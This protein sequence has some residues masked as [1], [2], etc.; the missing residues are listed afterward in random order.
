MT[1]PARDPDAGDNTGV[2]PD[3]EATTGRPRWQKVIGIVGLA[4]VL[5]FVLY[6]VLQVTGVVDAGLG[7]HTPAPGP[8]AGG[9][10]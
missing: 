5:L 2:A 6:V 3:R 10:R 1:N 4:L 8:P 7:G 9:H